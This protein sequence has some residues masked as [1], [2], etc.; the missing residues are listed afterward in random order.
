[1]VAITPS[2]IFRQSRIIITNCGDRE[3]ET[4]WWL[5]NQMSSVLE[6]ALPDYPLCSMLIAMTFQ[7]GPGAV[8]PSEEAGRD[9]DEQ[10]APCALRLRLSIRLRLSATCVQVSSQNHETWGR[11]LDVRTFQILSTKAHS[12]L[13]YNPVAKAFAKQIACCCW[14][15]PYKELCTWPWALVLYTSPGNLGLPFPSFYTWY[16]STPN[17][18]DFLWDKGSQSLGWVSD[19][20]LP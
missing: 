10:Q 1:M 17:F 9:T 13:F 15:P 5:W 19:S 4:E 14:E 11:C 20:S 18:P 3:N 7:S 16:G 8:P 2:G 12:I 6:P